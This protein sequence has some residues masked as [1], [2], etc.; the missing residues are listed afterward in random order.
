MAF[1]DSQSQFEILD[2]SLI[3]PDP[4]HVRQN[5]NEDALKGLT[6]AVQKL[7]VIH[8]LIVRPGAG[9]R[10]EV[11]A[12]ERRRLAAIQAGEAKVPAVI[13]ACTDDEALEVRVFENIG[14]GVRAA[15]E[16]REMANAIQAIAERFATPEEA[17]QHFG[18]SPTWLAQ[19]T[20]AANLSEK[21][22]ALLDS[23]KITSTSAAIQ[24][25]KL[26][27]KNEAK[28][29]S[30]IEQIEQLPE[31]ETVSKKVVDEVLQEARGKK[32]DELAPIA[33]P[34][35]TQQQAAPAMT[36]APMPAREDA[37]DKAS[38]ERHAPVQAPSVP[39]NRINPGKVKLVADLLGLSEDDEEELLVRLIDEFLSMKGV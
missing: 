12:G 36:E 17:A 34:T 21:V 20:A 9:G 4:T 25:E 5:V 8:P 3:D 37:L 29:D 18:R 22:T 31:G 32:A 2:L 1:K 39:R 13:R 33:E 15:L 28:A 14:L 24:L 6:N 38:E 11:V 19:A 35:P 27:K 30:F 7:G 16:P 26:S 23:G 10:F